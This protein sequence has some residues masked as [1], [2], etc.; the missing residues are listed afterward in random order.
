MKKLF[1]IA[2]IN[3]ANLKHNVTIIKRHQPN[4]KFL[5]MVKSNAY[6]HGATQI[7]TALL[8]SADG[9]GVA[10][11]EEALELRQAKINQPILLMKSFRDKY[12]LEIASQNNL[13]TV[14]FNEY[15]LQILEQTKLINPI[16]VWL[17]IDT[18]MH[19]LG[20][21]P[22]QVAAANNILM[23]NPQVK[24]PLGLITHFSDADDITNPK[25]EIQIRT[26]KTA[27]SE[28]LG[29]KSFANSATI[30][31]KSQ[32]LNSDWIR[33]G[34][35]M[36]GISPFQNQASTDLDLKPVMTLQST[37][38]DI[39]ELA[40]GETVGY[41][42]T[43]KCPEK[44]HIGIVNTGY[45][46]GYPRSAKTG[47]PVLINGKRCQIVGRVSMDML[48]VDL[49][50]CPNA[51]ITDPVIL[52]GE[53]LSASEIAKWADTIPYELFCRLTKRVQFEYL[54]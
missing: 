34:I 4:S 46:D 36:Y 5:A 10:C 13:Q 15:Q 45:G 31:S 38:I 41:G 54:S 30:F 20:F 7:A 12:E 2:K 53:D 37:L 16:T 33:S 23:Q 44:M 39:K 19:R 42:S 49:R 21:L 47:T 43:W 11:L 22:E 27:V 18:G 17:K 8:D 35:A 25:T 3:L 9:F 26:F 6:G 32:N 50:T 1:T 52:W 28:L 14:I 40:A 48:S 29:I 24:K 51:K